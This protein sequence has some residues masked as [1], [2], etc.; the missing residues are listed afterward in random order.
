MVATHVPSTST[1]P[2]ALR[3]NW[4]SPEAPCRRSML[5]AVWSTLFRC[6]LEAIQQHQVQLHLL[7]PM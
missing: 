5:E 7:H 6:Q 4:I 3:K 2:K 1:A